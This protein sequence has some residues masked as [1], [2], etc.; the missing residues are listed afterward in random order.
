VCISLDGRPR[1]INEFLSAVAAVQLLGP[2][3][4]ALDVLQVVACIEASVPFRRGSSRPG[5]GDDDEEESAADAGGPGFSTPVMVELHERCRGAA[6][7]LSSEPGAAADDGE[8]AVVALMRRRLVFG[9]QGEDWRD[10]SDDECEGAVARAVGLAADFANADVG[11]FGA[12]DPRAFLESTWSLLPEWY[13][14][15]LPPP[16]ARL[17]SGD[18]GSPPIGEATARDLEEALA[19]LLD[20]YPRVD[21]G[22]VFQ[23]F[24]GSLPRGAWRRRRDAALRNLGCAGRY[25][26]VRLACL[27]LALDAREAIRALVAQGAADG[28]SCA[29]RPCTLSFV[30]DMESGVPPHELNLLSSLTK[31]VVDSRLWSCLV[32]IRPDSGAFPSPPPWGD[33]A[34]TRASALVCLAVSWEGIEALSSP[35][36]PSPAAAA[37]TAHAG[38]AVRRHVAGPHARRLFADAVLAAAVAAPG[39]PRGAAA[40]APSLRRALHEALECSA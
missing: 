3:I 32:T 9:E 15:L 35:P 22:V 28:S 19:G 27:R 24:R 38:D 33:A 4:G 13:P 20:R 2:A 11:S 1:L 34:A 37:P 21:A 8:E 16:R 5:D 17:G 29:V 14:R 26:R 18:G 6:G 12:D 25:A 36:P 30:R 40:V 31:E 39:G 23:S 7:L 10:D